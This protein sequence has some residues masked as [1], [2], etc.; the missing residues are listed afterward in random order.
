MKNFKKLIAFSLLLSL[1]FLQLHSADSQSSQ[2][3]EFPKH[4]TEKYMYNK[5][6]ETQR[7]DSLYTAIFGKHPNG[8]SITDKTSEDLLSS[9]VSRKRVEARTENGVSIVTTETWISR[10]PSYLTWVNGAL[11]ISA[12]AAI[13]L[14]ATSVNALGNVTAA[15]VNAYGNVTAAGVNAAGNLGSTFI[16]LDEQKQQGIVN[17]FAMALS[18]PEVQNKLRSFN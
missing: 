12:I 15:G 18:D 2:D 13:V 17:G 5:S 14:G 1:S 10:N 3:L 9:R 6:V 7:H 4:T 8:I 11:V 16:G